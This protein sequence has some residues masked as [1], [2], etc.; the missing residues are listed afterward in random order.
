MGTNWLD[1]TYNVL[2]TADQFAAGFGDAVSFGATTKIREGIY[3]NL[4]TRNYEGGWFTGG[5]ITGAVAS[6]L[7]GFGTPDKIWKGLTWTQRGLQAYNVIGTGV[8]AYQGTRNLLDGCGNWTDLLNFAPA[9]GYALGS[10]KV[11]D[12]FDSVTGLTKNF[13]V[14]SFKLSKN[15]EILKQLPQARYGHVGISF[16]EG[17]KI[18]GFNP[19]VSEISHLSP[20]DIHKA[21]KSRQKFPGE[22]TDDTKEIFGKAR[23]LGLD[24]ER[25]SYEIGVSRYWKGRLKTK[26]DSVFSPLQNKKYMF[27]PKQGDFPPGCYNCATYPQSVGLP[28]PSRSG[29]LSEDL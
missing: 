20:N 10:D 13:D 8:G 24:V 2:N 21:L 6:T 7:A 9:F 23:D 29:K 15:R 16:D 27:P 1:T 12:L 5:Q 19:D 18:Y 25:N 22:V 4:A 14:F 3:G 28:T 26:F 17:N 11:G